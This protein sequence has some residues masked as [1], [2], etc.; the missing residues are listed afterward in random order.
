[1]A[2][3]KDSLSIA[4]MRLEVFLKSLKGIALTLLDLIQRFFRFLLDLFKTLWLGMSVFIMSIAILIISV[5]GSIWLVTHALDLQS[6]ESYQSM[7]ET[8][9]TQL[10][11]LWTAQE[12]RD[13][14]KTQARQD[15]VKIAEYTEMSCDVQSDCETP[16]EYLIRSSC[17]YESRCY[18]SQCVVVCPEF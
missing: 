2:K 8:R 16:P 14:Q 1:M 17:P 5:S 4:Q 9:L 6:S 11:E 13:A 3:K 10:F 18:E 15:N 7:R 12:K